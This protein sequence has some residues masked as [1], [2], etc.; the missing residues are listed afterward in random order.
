MLSSSPLLRKFATVENF[1]Q[2]SLTAFVSNRYLQQMRYLLP[3][4]KRL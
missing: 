4:N 3:Q 2:A 1:I